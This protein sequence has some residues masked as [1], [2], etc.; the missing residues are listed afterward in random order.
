MHVLNTSYALRACS[1]VVFLIKLFSRFWL[2]RLL[3]LARWNKTGGGAHCW[4]G[5]RRGG[6]HPPS[7]FLGAGGGAGKFPVGNVVPI[8]SLR[9]V[10]FFYSSVNPVR[11]FFSR[12]C[13]LFYVLSF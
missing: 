11:R 9:V 12:L 5:E 4:L 13:S 1:E 6:R 10:R 2:P 3:F 8:V 7:P